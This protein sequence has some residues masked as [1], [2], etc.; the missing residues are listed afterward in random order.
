MGHLTEITYRAFLACSGTGTTSTTSAGSAGGPGLG[1]IDW[2]VILGF[3]AGAALVALISAVGTLI[4][5]RRMP[6]VPAP[7]PVWPSSS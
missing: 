4:L 2:P 1:T 5:A 7:I 6:P 3:M